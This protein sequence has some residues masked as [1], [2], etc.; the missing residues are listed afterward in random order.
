MDD[1]ILHERCCRGDEL[2]WEQLVS[3]YQ[4]R[5][6]SVAYTYTGSEEEALDVA[7]EVFVRVWRRLDT[8]REP[9]RLG[10]WLL[11][12]ARNACLDHL[13]RRKARPPA[14]DLP[15]DE[16]FTLADPGR[17]PDAGIDQ[18]DQR[19]V[20]ERAMQRLSPISREAILLKDIQELT[21][22]DMA[23]MLDLP[24]G[25]VKSRCSRARVELAKVVAGLIA[26]GPDAKAAR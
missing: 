20:L 12:I 2:A 1:R 25:T 8:C 7:Q 22:E 11:Q 5:V 6:C 24:I 15:A 14:Q 18:E 9:E 17:R 3:R 13:R 26:P 10:A 4:A 19:H 16:L 23:T 21:L